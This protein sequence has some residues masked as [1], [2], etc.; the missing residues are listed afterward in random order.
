MESSE[1]KCDIHGKKVEC[2]CVHEDCKKQRFFCSKCARAHNIHD[3]EYLIDIEDFEKDPKILETALKINTASQSNDLFQGIEGGKDLF[4]KMDRR[5]EDLITELNVALEEECNTKCTALRELVVKL[6]S[7]F[8]QIK[9]KPRMTAEKY[10]QL[11]RTDI[12]RFAETLNSASNPQQN[13]NIEPIIREY[14]QAL[15]NINYCIHPATLETVKNKAIEELSKTLDLFTNPWVTWNTGESVVNFTSQGWK[16]ITTRALL[17]PF[18]A[19]VKVTGVTDQKA[20]EIGLTSQEITYPEE[21]IFGHERF[22]LNWF[23]RT[24]KYT[25]PNERQ[26]IVVKGDIDLSNNPEIT[27]KVDKENNATI[28]VDGNASVQQKLSPGMIVHLHFAANIE[29]ARAQI[30]SI[31]TESQA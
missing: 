27:I 2:F 16:N 18:E 26:G 13:E 14:K 6:Q 28:A 10:L 30:I 5:V 7:R 20:A 23:T 9:S 17:P 31:T 19:R 4:Q 25:P 21:R 11:F 24:V 29:S 1:L 22:Y 12:K 8:A 3:G 15:T